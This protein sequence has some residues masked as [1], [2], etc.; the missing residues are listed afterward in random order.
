MIGIDVVVP[1]KGTNSHLQSEAKYDGKNTSLVVA[2]G[3]NAVLRRTSV[4][5]FAVFAGIAG[6]QGQVVLVLGDG[7]AQV[8][9]DTCETEKVWFMSRSSCRIFKFHSLD[10]LQENN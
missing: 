9:E 4:R 5:F 7:S 2:V 6:A 8:L 1:E 3:H 10:K